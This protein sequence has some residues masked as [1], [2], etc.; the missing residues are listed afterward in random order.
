MPGLLIL[1]QS[2]YLLMPGLNGLSVNILIN[3]Q[4]VNQPKY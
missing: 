1:T 2:M 4:F 3:C